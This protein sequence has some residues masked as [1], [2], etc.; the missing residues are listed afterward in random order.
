MPAHLT[1]GSTYSCCSTALRRI[2]AGEMIIVIGAYED[3]AVSGGWRN[4]CLTS[5][6]AIVQDTTY[7]IMNYCTVVH[8][9]RAIVEPAHWYA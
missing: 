8:E 7:N 1:V 2:R 3:P 4:V 9:E 6:G 5:D